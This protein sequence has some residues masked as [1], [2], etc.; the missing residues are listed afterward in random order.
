MQTTITTKIRIEEMI[1]ATVVSHQDPQRQ[2]TAHTLAVVKVI[3]STIPQKTLRLLTHPKMSSTCFLT[4]F[5][6]F[7]SNETAQW[8]CCVSEEFAIGLLITM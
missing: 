2:T 6:V 4:F 3:A 8:R 7:V 1:Q 5:H